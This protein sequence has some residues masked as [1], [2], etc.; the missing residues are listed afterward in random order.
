MIR[1]SNDHRVDGARTAATLRVANCTRSA[2]R[3]LIERFDRERL[4]NTIHCGIAPRV[5]RGGLGEHDRRDDHVGSVGK[6]P[7]QSYAD[8]LFFAGERRERA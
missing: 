3:W 5:A 8:R 6:C 2:G 7:A 1:A 4:E